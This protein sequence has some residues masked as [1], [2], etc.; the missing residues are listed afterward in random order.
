MRE[1]DVNNRG[2]ALIARAP[3]GA[4]RSSDPGAGNR[5]A[6]TRF[7]GKRFPAVSRCDACEKNLPAGL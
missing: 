7:A 1:T 5:Q 3:P 4:G 2:R 6:G